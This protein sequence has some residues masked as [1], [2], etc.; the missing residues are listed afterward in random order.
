MLPKEFD[1][2]DIFGNQRASLLL[3]AIILPTCVHMC[4]TRKQSRINLRTTAFRVE[5]MHFLHAHAVSV[6]LILGVLVR[7]SPACQL[8]TTATAVRVVVATS[9]ASVVVIMPLVAA[10]VF[11]QSNHLRHGGPFSGLTRRPCPK[12]P[13]LWRLG[14]VL[15]PCAL[16]R[17]CLLAGYV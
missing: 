12:Y 9:G 5:G 6:I 13:R 15:C 17:V 16:Q 7:Y 1:A 14:P 2:H 4:S 3:W 11:L 10:M 8:A